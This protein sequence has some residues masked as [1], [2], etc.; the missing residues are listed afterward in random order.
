MNVRLQGAAVLLV[1]LCVA[2]GSAACGKAKEAERAGGPA[3]GNGVD[4]GVLLPDSTAR[5]YNFDR[6]L[7]EKKIHELCPSCSVEAVSAQH[8]VATQQ[9]QMDAMIT[10][11]AK[12][13]I[14]D[15]VDSK[16]LRSSVDSARRAGTEVI[17]YDRLAEG[18][19]S[20]FVS[21]DG[22]RVGRL[23]GEALLKALGAK[24]HGGQ[25]VMMNG[26]STDP[27]AAWFEKGALAA[28]K[29]KV[30]IG[31]SYETVGWRPANANINM[32]GAIAALGA[33][34]IDGVYSANDGLAS[35]IISALKAAKI[36]PLPPVTGQDA[37]LAAMQRIVKGEQYM[38]VYKPFKPEAYTAATMA[39]ALV[40][41]ERLDGIAKDRI[42]S[43]TTR[44]IPAVLLTPISVTA[45]NIK[46][47]V[48]KDGMYTIDQICTPKFASA[49]EKAGLTR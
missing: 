44:D 43:A 42:N 12:V 35:G 14:L 47:T 37:E 36:E 16:S 41:G 19:I 46:N 22:E 8:D 3:S 7:I 21:F 31:K 25:I 33:D 27:N 15:A 24:A 18:P 45:G 20:G 4:I 17:A 39:V 10:K 48:V 29:S 6:P 5:F 9:Q 1:A 49:C 32:S 30:R 38:S 2:T 11:R 26:S 28:L 34:R 13:L 23:Q 40:R